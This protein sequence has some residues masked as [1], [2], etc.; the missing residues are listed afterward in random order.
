M[1]HNF[2]S[3]LLK[4]T[5]ILFAL[6]TPVAA[7]D[8][9]LAGNDNCAR[10]GLMIGIVDLTNL[11][12]NAKGQRSPNSF[13]ALNSAVNSVNS[14]VVSSHLQKSGYSNNIADFEAY[15][16]DLNRFIQV[17]Q[18]NGPQFGGWILNRQS[19]QDRHERMLQ[20]SKDLC[21]VNPLEQTFDILERAA[22]QLGLTKAKGSELKKLSLSKPKKS[23]WS[24]P[25]RVRKE[26]LLLMQ[27]FFL[28]ASVLLLIF[29]TKLL[30]TFLNALRLDR[31]SCAIP[32]TLDIGG[33]EI[34]GCIDIISTR[35]LSFQIT[36]NN[37]S[38]NEE[39]LKLDRHVEFL[40]EAFNFLGILTVKFDGGA[41]FRLSVPLGKNNLRKLLALSETPPR[42]KIEMPRKK[43]PA[44]PTRASL[45]FKNRRSPAE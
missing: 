39:I 17:R 45:A 29:V 40:T 42:R 12:L 44:R 9:D 13:N 6:G 25:F 16:Q 35:G 7:A 23:S 14:K 3:N 24:K 28:L 34:S 38:S 19:F 11:L 1:F 21:H 41:G 43:K 2:V 20:L 26:I 4:S 27:V 37:I 15:I 30:M 10:L 18:V 8:Q 36:D 33:V 31:F 5:L 22:S 32:A